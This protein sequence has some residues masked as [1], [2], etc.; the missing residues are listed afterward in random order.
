VWLGLSQLHTLLDVDLDKVSFAALAA[1]LPRL[2]TL[3]AVYDY[4]SASNATAVKGFFTDLLPRL[5]VFHFSGMWPS[6]DATAAIAPLPQLEEL[7]WYDGSTNPTAIR[8]LTGFLGARPIVAHAPY[9]LVAECLP[10]R[11]GAADELVRGF[12]ARVCELRL[13][14]FSRVS[15]SD[16]AQ[17]LRAAPRLRTFSCTRDLRGDTSFLTALGRPLHPAFVGLVHS[18]LRR[19]TLS[20]HVSLPPRDDGCASRLRQ[21]CFPRLRMMRV[22]RETY[23]VTPDAAGRYQILDS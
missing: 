1:A 4:D 8:Q 23:F 5:R 7:M 20:T 19:L 18:R 13:D 9:E 17:V 12:L 3:R 22:N 14:A 2:R 21:T 6:E 16:V 10:G 15:V 11:S